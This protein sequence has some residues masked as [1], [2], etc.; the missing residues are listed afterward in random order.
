LNDRLETFDRYCT[1]M[2]MLPNDKIYMPEHDGFP[3]HSRHRDKQMNRV[4]LSVCESL[5][6][7]TARHMLRH[8]NFVPVTRSSVCSRAFDAVSNYN[9]LHLHYILYRRRRCCH[10]RS[11]DLFLSCGWP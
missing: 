6:K 10:H 5:K 9:D 3:Y 8:V 1:Y 7:I 11:R 2:T 4:Y